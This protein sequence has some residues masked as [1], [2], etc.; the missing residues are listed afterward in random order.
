MVSV[1]VSVEDIEIVFPLLD[2][3]VAPPPLNLIVSPAD[4]FSFAAPFALMLKL[5]VLVLVS[6]SVKVKGFLIYIRY[7]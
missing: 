2:T 1:L 6:V 4:M 5:V 3:V 7:M